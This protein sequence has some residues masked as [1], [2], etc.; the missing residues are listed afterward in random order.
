MGCYLEDYGARV[1]TWAGRFSWRGG[2]RRGDTN[3][4]IGGCLGMTM[5]SSVVLAVLLV[6]G[7]VEQNPG[8]VTEGE[9]DMQVVCIGCGR[10]LKSGI[11]CELC[12]RWYHYS[13]GN[14][15]ASVPEREKWSCD[16]CRIETIRVL[17]E[18]LQ[19]A[20]HQIDE[21]RARNRELEEQV[22]RAGAGKSDAVVTQKD[23]KCLVM[24]NSILRNVGAEH[25]DLMV[26]CFQGI[27]AEQLHSDRKE[28]ARKSRNSYNPRRHK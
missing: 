16:K 14:V 9:M 22:Q 26:E 1:G 15:K 7:G 2:P 3:R 8:P 23:T 10:N 24:G 6:I 28:G 4:Y 17:Q 25:P 21:L 20:L 13:C 5:L 18:E 19:N 27:R 12:G 11:Q